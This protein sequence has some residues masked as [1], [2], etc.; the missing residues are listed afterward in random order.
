MT[1]IR[2]R[3][4]IASATLAGFG[5]LLMMV[6]AVQAAPQPATETLARDSVRLEL[7]D[8]ELRDQDG[9]TVRLLS[10]VIQDRMAVVSFVYTRCTTACPLTAAMLSKLQGALGD[11]LDRDVRIV[12][13]S[14]DPTTDTPQRLKEYGQKFHARPGW[15]WLTG[16]PATIK[17]LLQDMGVYTPDFTAH[18]PVI[19]IGDAQR[20]LWIRLYGFQTPKQLLGQI[21]RLQPTR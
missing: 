2:T 18:S 16:S 10:D 9:Q 17:R 3:Q 20:K 5:Y 8:L 19:L 11:R 12:S 7:P 4:L 14:L 15:R 1:I 13:L 21:E 6:S